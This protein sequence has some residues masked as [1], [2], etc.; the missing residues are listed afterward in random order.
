M[1]SIGSSALSTISIGVLL[2][3]LTLDF[4]VENSL[5][6]DNLFMLILFGFAVPAALQQRVLLYGIVGALVLRGVF[7][8]AGA[9]MLQAGTWAFLAVVV[10]AIFATDVV[11]A[12]VVACAALWGGR[13]PAAPD[14]GD[15]PGH[16]VRMRRRDGRL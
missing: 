5:S 13:R 3:L 14:P 6:V 2:A 11:V 1:E 12:L 15:L 7:I 4:V 8:A 10:V 9:A 16:R